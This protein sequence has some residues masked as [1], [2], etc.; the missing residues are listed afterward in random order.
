ML[1][2]SSNLTSSL[3]D[4]KFIFTGENF[5]SAVTSLPLFGDFHQRAAD[6]ADSGAAFVQF[7]IS[8][9]A[10]GKR[11]LIMCVCRHCTIGVS[12]N[13]VGLMP[14]VEI[15]EDSSEHDRFSL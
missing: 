14:F 2:L 10:S 1:L 7:N 3:T 13:W 11:Q 15:N 12:W 8:S 4:D 6:D 9:T 5:F